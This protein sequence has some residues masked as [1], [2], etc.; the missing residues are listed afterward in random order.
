MTQVT[1]N[2]SFMP[3]DFVEA[4]S[5]SDMMR[6]PTDGN[7][8]RYVI[9][10]VGVGGW[11]YW[12]D[13]KNCYRSKQQFVDTPGIKA[14]DSQQQFIMLNVLNLDTLK[15][16]ILELSKKTLRV[17]TQALVDSGDYCYFDPNKFKPAATR[18]TTN[19]QALDA[20]VE[21]A[22]LSRPK[23]VIAISGFRISRVG[24]GMQDTKYTVS[25]TPIKQG[26]EQTAYENIEESDLVDLEKFAF[27][28]REPKADI[29]EAIPT[30]M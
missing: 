6:M 15:M 29:V 12:D 8:I 23:A 7:S 16:S 30:V 18:A 27:A 13:K 24:S 4:A 1:S 14:G 5:S 3:V 17:Q 28:K 9:V 10:G 21:A 19:D 25:T 22:E 26:A 11:Y 20:F 2:N